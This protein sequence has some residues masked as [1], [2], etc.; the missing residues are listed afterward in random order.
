MKLTRGAGTLLCAVAL[1]DVGSMGAQA[2]PLT[3]DDAV[4]RAATASPAAAAAVA[5][6]QELV[7]RAR[8]E[9]QWANPLIELRRE[10]EGAPIP[11]DDFA[12]VT[13]PVGVT[14]RRV[15]LRAALAAT[16]DRATA[17]SLEVV[18]AAG[19]EAA[20]A[21]WAYWAARA[22][23]EVA[24]AHAALLDRI[25][26]LDSLRAAE[27]ELAEASAFRMRL[28]AQRGR[29]AAAQA[30]AAA[31]HARARLAAV[32][33]EGDPEAIDVGEP[34]RVATTL[35]S[36]EVA[37]AAATQDRPDVRAA[38]AA[39]RAADRR[40]TAE[41]LGTLPDVGLTGGYKGTG[42]FETA[43]FGVMVTAPVFNTN[44]GNRERAAGEWLQ[45]DA[46]RRATER[47]ATTEVRAAL[48]AARVIE[49]GTAG[50]DDAFVARADVVAGAAEAAYREGAA[51]LI[52]LLD[53]FRAAADARTARVRGLQDRALARLDLRRAMGAPAVETP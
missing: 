43:L 35:P 36:V 34:P 10:N 7:G 33:D 19:F 1:L 44:G 38:Q 20:R 15:A 23:A 49:D 29:H 28:E 3:L 39:V 9:A 18:R 2:R 4:R 13:F 25:A 21:W 45:A 52:E 40:R 30:V 16:R 50:F 41:R 53:A 42:G 47:R 11:Y 51:S 12:T 8:T 14:G 5:R 24:S 37:L 27:G 6:R 48:I 26:A 17:D 22:E 31:A 46:E 32:V